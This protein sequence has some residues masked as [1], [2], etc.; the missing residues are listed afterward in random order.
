M[1]NVTSLE[2]LKKKMQIGDYGQVAAVLGC[3]RDAAKMRLK[4]HKPEAI[5]ALRR[6][7]E[8]REELAKEFQNQSL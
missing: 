4:R 3:T 7:I 2:Q 5:E 6:L 8:A 1:E